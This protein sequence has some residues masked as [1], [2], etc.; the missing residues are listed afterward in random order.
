MVHYHVVASNDMGHFGISP[1]NL[2]HHILT[3]VI[4]KIHQNID[5]ATHKE[6][7][8]INYF[9]LK[10]G[11]SNEWTYK[12]NNDEITIKYNLNKFDHKTMIYNSNA[13]SQ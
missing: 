5:Y 11:L 1:H 7:H 2:P 9:I 10:Q 8:S 12:Y 3:F 6:D 4:N 13:K